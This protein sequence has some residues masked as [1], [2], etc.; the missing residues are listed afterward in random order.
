MHTRE[1]TTRCGSV[2]LLVARYPR[3]KYALP[4]ADLRVAETPVERRRVGG[5]TL[6]VKRDDLSAPT[7]G[8]NKVRALQLLLAGVTPDRTLLT[9]GPT[10]ST[11]ALAVAHH[12]RQL[13][14]DTEVITWPQEV[15]DVA[16]ATSARMTELAR[17]AHAHS[18]MEAYLRAAVRRLRGRVHWIPAGGSAPLG[19]LGHAGAALELVEQ[20]ARE[21]IPM[22]ATIV[23]PLGSGG[24]V[25]GLLLGLAIAGVSTRVVGVRVV[26]RIVGNRGH[27][28]RLAWSSRRLL[29]RLAGEPVPPISATALTIDHA[30]YGGAY[31]RQTP[32]GA[33]AAE[34]FRQAGGLRLDPTYSEKAFGHALALARHAPDGAVLFW[35]TFDGRWLADTDDTT[36]GFR[37]PR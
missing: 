21:G 37:P 10:G 4:H 5:T 20:L 24:T 17:V 8:G 1:P 11:H 35:L 12:G 19:V 36:R 33:H 26:P 22:P 28:L 15:H 25:A 3:L 6:M 9:V 27:V 23:V 29:R 32:A 34:S 31:G 16:L 30:S 18:P 13:G 14:L 2:D 7:L